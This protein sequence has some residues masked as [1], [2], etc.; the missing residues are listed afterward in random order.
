MVTTASLRADRLPPQAKSLVIPNPFGER[1]THDQDTSKFWR[2]DS[3][4]G[5]TIQIV[6]GRESVRSSSSVL[7]CKATI[8]SCVSDIFLSLNAEYPQV[9][10]VKPPSA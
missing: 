2:G 3:N 8:A 9:P 10:R 1:M 5:F 4:N 6:G 7:W